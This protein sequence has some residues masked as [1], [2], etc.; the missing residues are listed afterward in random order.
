MSGPG[1]LL[2]RTK[3]L[4]WRTRRKRYLAIEQ[5]LRSLWGVL[6]VEWPGADLSVVC[7]GL[8]GTRGQSTWYAPTTT[9][10]FRII[11]D[12]ARLRSLAANGRRFFAVTHPTWSSSSRLTIKS[13]LCLA[14]LSKLREVTWK[15]MWWITVTWPSDLQETGVPGFLNYKLSPHF[16]GQNWDQLWRAAEPEWS[17]FRRRNARLVNQLQRQPPCW[18]MRLQIELNWFA[19]WRGAMGLLNEVIV[20]DSGVLN[21]CWQQ[22]CAKLT[23]FS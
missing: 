21:C 20:T 5:L 17:W 9:A 2:K 15:K 1:E 3:Q 22:K 7:V 19:D 12:W 10:T 23:G 8:L 14:L 13:K 11:G 16:A 6:S 4:T 18:L